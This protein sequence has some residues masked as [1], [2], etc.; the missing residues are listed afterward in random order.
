MQPQWIACYC[1]S[2]LG[3]RL[4]GSEQANVNW[5]PAQ[6]YTQRILSTSFQKFASIIV[7]WLKYVPCFG[8]YG[9]SLILWQSLTISIGANN[10]H[11][12][13]GIC[14][15]SKWLRPSELTC[16]ILT[17][18]FSDGQP[19]GLLSWMIRTHLPWFSP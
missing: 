12:V 2:F 10:Y 1:F 9:N 16:H 11:W 17:S 7:Y 19:L 13:L 14:P 4:V 5:H 6:P 18:S 3:I 15:E 8:Y